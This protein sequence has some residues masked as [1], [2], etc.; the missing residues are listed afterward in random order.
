MTIRL[1]IADD[2]PEIRSAV[3]D[4]ADLD[5]ELELAGTAEDADGAVAVA[6]DHRPDVFLVDVR[7][8][9]GGP[10]AAREIRVVSPDTRVVAFSAWEDRSTVLEMLR[11]GAVAYVTKGAETEDILSAITR[12]ARG[13]STLSPEV[14]GEVVEELTLR[15]RHQEHLDQRRHESVDGIVEVLRK[16]GTLQIVYQ[17]I[18]DLRTGLA[19]GGEALSRF[20]I[21]PHRPP[22]QWF[23]DAAE[24]GMANVL[25]TAAAS[26]ALSDLADLPSRAYLAINMS[27]A[28]ILDPMFVGLFADGP[29]D[30]VV[31]EVTEHAQVE[32]YDLLAEALRPFRDRGLR[33]AVDDAG[34]GY[35]GLRHILQ[36]APDIVKLDTEL[37][38]G[39]EQDRA[40]RA[41]AEALITFAE[42]MDLVIVAEGIET[43]DEL[44]A[45][46]ALGVPCGQGFHL[47]RPKPLPLRTRSART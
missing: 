25:E 17:P 10:Q 6:R 27:P 20:Q 36:M 45:L 47:G 40:R 15:L 9:G 24:V 4:L 8:P 35:A 2:D 30:R 29:V 37:T 28:A 22:D 32:D 23:R 12:A 16:P 41:L 14:S 21:A 42:A 26:A 11:S 43:P 5:P 46:R 34:S 13:H 44:Q 7:M 3:A 1:G 19:V 18:F 39:I 31:L 38:R 33:L